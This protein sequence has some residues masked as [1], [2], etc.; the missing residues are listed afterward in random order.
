[1]I[2]KGNALVID[3]RDAPEVE[4]SGKIAVGCKADIEQAGPSLR[5]VMMNLS[6]S[7]GRSALLPIAAPVEGSRRDMDRE[8]RTYR[9]P[10]SPG[11]GTHPDIFRRSTG[12]R[13][14]EARI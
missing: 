2:A 12:T 5:P 10:C 6:A 4:K 14:G 11:L 7:I 1:M 9:R 3:V 13:A 8:P